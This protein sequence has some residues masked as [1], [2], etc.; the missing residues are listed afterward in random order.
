MFFLLK[1]PAFLGFLLFHN[2]VRK[3]E[4]SVFKGLVHTKVKLHSLP[5]NTMKREGWVE[6]SVLRF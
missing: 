3:F 4:E 2:L 5:I 1:L 6:G